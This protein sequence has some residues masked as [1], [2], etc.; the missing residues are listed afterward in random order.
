[1]AMGKSGL[2]TIIEHI[3]NDIFE[4][5]MLNQLPLDVQEI[6]Q[7]QIDLEK[8]KLTART[9]IGKARIE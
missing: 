5:E 6:S 9:D 8:A 4:E 3:N 2:T 7:A 1:M